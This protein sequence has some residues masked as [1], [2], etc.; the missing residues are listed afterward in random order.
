MSQHLTRTAVT[1]LGTLLTPPELAFEAS[2][3]AAE[4]NPEAELSPHSTKLHIPTF[5]ASEGNTLFPMFV[6][7]EQFN[8]LIVGGGAIGLEKITAVLRNSPRTRVTLVASAIAPEIQAFVRDYP[9]VRLVEKPFES[10]DLAG[11]HF[12]IVATDDKAT[13]AHVQGV[14][15]ARGILTNVA[16]TPELC[17]FYLSSIVQK[18]D[19]KIAISTNGKSPTLAKRLKETLAELLPDNLHDTAHNLAQIRSGL[20]GDFATKVQRLNEITS[21][22]AAKNAPSSQPGNVDSRWQNSWQRTWQKTW[23]RTLHA[24][25]RVLFA[26]L[27]VVGIIILDRTL[28]PPMHVDTGFQMFFQN[29]TAV[30]PPLDWTFAGYIGIGFVA[31]MIDGAFGMAYGPTVTSF[32][33]A[34][35]ISP[36]VASATLHTSE[37]FAS[38]TAALVYNRHRNINAKLFK[39]LA[40]AGVLGAICGAALL[41]VLSKEYLSVV[42]PFV[43]L[44]TLS[45]GV[46][47]IARSR[48]STRRRKPTRP[49]LTRPIG[50][51]GALFDSIGGGGWGA[52][53]TSSLLAT[54][55]DLRYT[56]GSAHAAKF[57]VAVASTITFTLLIGF[58]HWFIVLGLVLGGTVAAPFSIAIGNR[59]PKQTGLLLVG[60]V[61]IL[62]SLRSLARF[63]GIL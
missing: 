30:L 17:D 16:D 43:A 1:P 54:G 21:V 55:R 61:V 3:G 42:K 7:L 25:P 31:Q 32:L 34:F 10:S 57:F 50:F 27:L 53:V 18:G 26:L 58:H 39:N 62:V 38:G 15:K 4:G 28:L 33:M 6:K 46:L 59:I 24:A 12:V 5:L 23:Q 48:M 44:Y 51:L 8:V 60:V 47:I 63:F 19:V 37:V 49:K 45:L 56:I 13:N 35:G 9:Q 52:L 40:V 14:A 11:Q 20:Q 36:A 29:V 22:L 2:F 41:S